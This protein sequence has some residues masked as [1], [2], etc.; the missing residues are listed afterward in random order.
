MQSAPNS[1]E[2]LDFHD[3][4]FLARVALDLAVAIDQDSDPGD[5]RI[6]KLLPVA[7]FKR[8]K[9]AKRNHNAAKGWLRASYGLQDVRAER[10]IALHLTHQLGG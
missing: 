5:E 10:I 2:S 9:T 4:K 6:A 8:P 7:I 3:L 1:I